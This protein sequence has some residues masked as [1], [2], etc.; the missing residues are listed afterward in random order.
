MNDNFLNTAFSEQEQTAI[1][2][3]DVD[4]KTQDRIFLLS[5]NEAFH[6][7]FTKLV[8]RMCAPTE[9]AIDNG[10]YVS[11]EYFVDGRGA[12]MWWLRASMWENGFMA[13]EVIDD[14]DRRC[15]PVEYTDLCVRPVF[16]LN[17]KAE[18]TGETPSPTAAPKAN[19][20]ATT[21][22]NDMTREWFQSNPE[23]G[24]DQ[25]Y[26][27]VSVSEAEMVPRDTGSFF[28]WRFNPLFKETH[29][30][31]F[32]I[33][34]Y[35]IRWFNE[36]GTAIPDWDSA[37]EEDIQALLGRTTVSGKGGFSSSVGIEYDLPGTSRLNGFGI[38]LTGE[39][40]DGNV[41]EF[42]G[43]G[44]LQ[45]VE[46]GAADPTPKPTATVT[47]APKAD[48]KATT[49]PND[50]TREWFQSN[51]ETGADQPYVTIRI[52]EEELYPRDT[53]DN[54]GWMFDP[55]FK[56]THGHSLRITRYMIRWFNESGVAIP[57]WNFTEEQEFQNFMGRTTVSPNDSFSSGVGIQ[58][59]LPNV[60]RLNGVGILL[61]GED[62]A[63]NVY[64]FRVYGELHGA[65]E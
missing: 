35:M 58:Y 13:S 33:T 3:T 46:E 55:I 44:E 64:E 1:L 59:E 23:T 40:K 50:M 43:Y 45:W 6:Q 11:S 20:K 28:G 2:I 31:S 8:D 60:S 41:Y 36:F 22:P 30:Q 53:G 38:L 9:Y 56:E 26:I 51:P 7:Y 42:R 34:R 48:P 49:S 32:R 27:T 57:D 14:G 63:G 65:G 10:A 54:F 4:G 39:D 29:G 16:W 15:S 61:T 24:A 47:A 25:P 5:D 19:P 12:G 17:T 37:T 52:R 62:E 18:P 21:S